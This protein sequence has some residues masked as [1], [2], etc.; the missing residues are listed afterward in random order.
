MLDNISL[1][2]CMLD[3]LGIKRN[4]SS[5]SICPFEV[6]SCTI[7]TPL[8]ERTEHRADSTAD[9]VKSQNHLLRYNDPNPLPQSKKC[10]HGDAPLPRLS[11][12]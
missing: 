10:R 12:G 4:C 3:T 5:L 1:G 11:R 6:R 9:T 2:K 7:S 8:L